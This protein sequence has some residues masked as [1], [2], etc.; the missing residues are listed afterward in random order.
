MVSTSRYSSTDPGEGSTDEVDYEGQHGLED[1]TPRL[2]LSMEDTLEGEVIQEVP[3]H[4]FL[5]ANPAAVTAVWATENTRDAIFDGMKN[6]ET[7]ATSGNRPT[8]RFFG[9]WSDSVYTKAAMCDPG[10]DKA[11]AKIGYGHGVAMGQSP[12]E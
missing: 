9:S 6:R 2:R 12:L 10:T 8:V 5:E 11:F 1:A 7:Y 3:K 4:S